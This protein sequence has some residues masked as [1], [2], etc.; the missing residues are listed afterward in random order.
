MNDS[1]VT[2]ISINR[3]R[4]M[5]DIVT[6]HS[7]FVL[8]SVENA[9]IYDLGRKKRDTDIKSMLEEIVNGR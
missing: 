5:K 7:P 2:K 4:N 9:V 8:S 1:F 3:V 6:T